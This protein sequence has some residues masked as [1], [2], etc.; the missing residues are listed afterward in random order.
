MFNKR[1][2]ISFLL[3]IFLFKTKVI[4]KL[5]NIGNISFIELNKF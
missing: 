1:T 4:N 2:I 3:S 5:F